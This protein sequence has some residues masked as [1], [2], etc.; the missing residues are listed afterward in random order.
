MIFNSFNNNSV[1][2]LKDLFVQSHISYSKCGLGTKETDI[3]LDLLLNSNNNINPIIGA[4]ISGGGG[5]G[6]VVVLFNKSHENKLSEVYKTFWNEIQSKYYN[7]TGLKCTIRKG[8][9]GPLAFHGHSYRSF[10]TLI[11]PRVLYVNHG[12]PPNFNGGSE[13]YAQTL[14]L[15]ILSSGDCN[16]VQVFAREHDPYRSDYEM[17]TTTDEANSNL[18]MNLVN[19]PRE[20]PYYRFVSDSIDNAFRNLLHQM[21]PD[22]VHFHHLNHLSLNLPSIV[23]SET[24]AKTFYTIHD[25]WLMCPRGQFLMTGATSNEP[26]KQCYHQNNEKCAKNCFISRYS[27]GNEIILEEGFET[28]LYESNELSYWS[29][30]IDKRM[31]SIIHATSNIDT[32]IAPSKYL[33]NKFIQEFNI[34]KDKILFQ[35]YGIDHNRLL[36]RKRIRGLST[37]SNPYIFG[38]IGRHQPAKGINILVEAT[39][40]L[41]RDYPGINEIFKVKIYSKSEPNSIMALNRMIQESGIDDIN[42]NIE[43]CN[44][45]NNFNIVQD[46][47]NHIDIIVVPS[48]WEENSPIAIL[49]AQQCKIPVITSDFGGMKELVEDNIN[50]LLFKHRDATSLAEVMLKAINQSLYMNTLG[51]RGYLYNQDGQVPSIRDQG[52]KI[53]NMYKNDI[54]ETLDNNNSNQSNKHNIPIRI[55]F[56]TNPDDCNFSCTMCEQHS[57][58]SPHQKQRKLEGKRRRRM[59]FNLIEKVLKEMVPLGTKEVIPTTMGEPLQYKEFP[60]LI[61]LCNELNIKMNLTTNGSFYGRGVDQWARLIIPITSDV[62]FSWNGATEQTQQKI[63]KGSKLSTQ[64][65]N[66]KH[67]I[68][69]RDEIAST[70]D[71]NR[72]NVT[73]QL[74]FMEDNLNEIPDIIALAIDYGCDRV[75]GHHLW[76][77]FNEIKKQNLRKN[78]DSIN[79]WNEIAKQCRDYVHK[80]KLANGKYLILE[81]FI[82]LKHTSDNNDKLSYSNNNDELI[83]E[84]SINIDTLV[85]DT[86]ECPFL[87]KEAW[88]NHEGRFD[89]CCAPDEQRKS[90]GS[91]GNINDIS[92]L[93]IWTSKKYKDLMMNYK[94]YPLCKT[95]TMRK[96]IA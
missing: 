8:N 35:P 4:K 7:E 29:N 87:G 51:Q 30:W 34:A 3:L 94:S 49:E 96:P 54:K 1:P 85:N 61:N 63:M 95:C 21:Q 55:T 27:T 67:F 6:S 31:K 22:I 92:L 57:E 5:G 24:L 38:Y 75:K 56:D 10:S 82:D 40:K 36:N 69:I 90:L 41:I 13:V 84:S 25:Y 71:G 60:N 76:A 32:F 66:L 39:L 28:I 83:K 73:L 46:V 52:N 45:Y 78:E 62:K 33:L 2:L 74:T 53:I 47:F 48:I 44:P 93:D 64:L 72:C 79:R 65:V 89:P 9:S 68:K 11:R 88:I 12:Y 18:M 37:S 14:A 58:F 19:Y 80:H 91:F 17:R 50:G 42:N 15:E 16:D 70:L 23:K 20:A 43:F 26:W 86:Y 81:N 59:D 77:H